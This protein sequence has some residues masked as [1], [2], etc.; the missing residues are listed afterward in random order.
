MNDK[1]LMILLPHEHGAWAMLVVP[2]LVGV[3]AS[4]V[5]DIRVVL[6][7]LAVF[8][9]FML[10]YP[11]VLLVKSRAAEVRE[12]AMRWSVIYAALTSVDA[13]VLLALTRLWLL[14]PLGLL[15][16]VSLVVYLWLAA[17]RVE[18][19]T[20]G[21]WIG[22]AGLA[23][24]APGA[25]LIGRG[26]L[27]A[28]AVALYALNLLYF[29][30]TVSYIKFKVREQ[31]RSVPPGASWT[32][33]IAAG[34]ATVIYHA[35]VLAS[36]LVLAVAGILPALAA[37]AFVLPVCKVVGGVSVRP[38]RLSLTRLGAV[39]TAVTAAFALALLAAYI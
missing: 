11:L 14:I 32:E 13:A 19:S 5:L 1:K 6:F 31:M 29:G 4:R 10:R 36:A 22:I 2:L 8:G 33:R 21:E 24:G 7:L 9:F 28:T 30:G 39:E 18:M 27:D 17:R 15:G 3:G 23:L 35:L 16:L 12:N 34:R 37:L 38:S 26:A 25:Y 20:A